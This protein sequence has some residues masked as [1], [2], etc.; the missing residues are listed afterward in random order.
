MLKS[1]KQKALQATKLLILYPNQPSQ[2]QI[3]KGGRN[4]LHMLSA[5]DNNK[6][7]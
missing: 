6:D 4:T 1:T 5:N 3:K 2:Q 7:T